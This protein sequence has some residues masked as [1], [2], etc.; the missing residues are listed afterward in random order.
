ME[1]NIG[2]AFDESTG[3]FVCPHDGLYTFYV[4]SLVSKGKSGNV[5][6]VL[7]GSNKIN[8]LVSP[9]YAH[10]S[11]YGSFKLKKSDTVHIYM[12]GYFYYSNSECYRTYFEGRLIDLL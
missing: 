5:Y 1:Y 9:G 2:N 11:P 3:N 4:T 10:P 6:I 12:S 8:H 7:N